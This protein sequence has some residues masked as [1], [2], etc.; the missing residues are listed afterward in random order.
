MAQDGRKRERLCVVAK[1]HRY[2]PQIKAL[3][4]AVVSPLSGHADTVRKR[5]TTHPT[6]VAA[7]FPRLLSARQ[8]E[9]RH[10]ILNALF[11]HLKA[12]SSVFFDTIR[13]TFLAKVRT[14]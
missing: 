2:Q 12:S 13:R 14:H 5:K 6:S 11:S 4:L 9:L 7:F 10:Q 1:L 8:S 3:M